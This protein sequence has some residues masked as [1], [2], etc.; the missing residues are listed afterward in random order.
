VIFAAG[1]VMLF[2]AARIGF[3]AAAALWLVHAQS[4]VVLFQSVCFVEASS[5][6]DE[7]PE[8]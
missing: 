3:R 4:P 7:S 8:L 2:Q 5:A 1:N 6:H